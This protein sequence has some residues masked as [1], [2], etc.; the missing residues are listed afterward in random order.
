[1]ENLA[2][3]PGLLLWYW[4]MGMFM[5]SLFCIGHDCGHEVFSDY[6]WANDFFGHVAHAAI[7]VPYWPWQKSHRQHHKFTSHVEKDKGHPWVLEEDYEKSD[8][9][10]R[11]FSKIPLSGLIRWTPLYTMVGLPDGSHFWPY[12][13]LFETNQDRVKC[14]VSVAACALTSLIVFTA[15]C[16]YS[17]ILFVKY[18][19]VPLMFQGMWI[20]MI[21]H[22][23]HQDEEI[24]VYEEGHW[25]FMR[26]Q[27][28][29]IDRKYGFGLDILLHHITDGHVAH[30]FFF[31]K[32]PH[33]HLPEATRAIRK[34]LEKYPG[35]YKRRS[36][37]HFLYEFLRLNVQLDCLV[38]MGTGLL[39]YKSAVTKSQKSQ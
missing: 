10:H 33:Y 11:H 38:G 23:Q 28:Q 36:C 20:V 31:T 18:Y 15:F 24:E 25:N 35:T 22:L 13:K 5:S 14:V 6:T 29:T 4:V 21:T 19:Y 1:V 7:M 39:K 32:V 12:S 16:N 27:L 3:W 17:P 34:V 30:H 8:W 26:G 37:Y 2:G 9:L